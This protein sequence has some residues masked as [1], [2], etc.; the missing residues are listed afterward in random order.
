MVLDSTYDATLERAVKR[1]IARNL[2][3][4]VAGQVVEGYARTYWFTVNSFSHPATI[5]AVRL[6]YDAEGISFQCDCEGAMHDRLCAHVA[7]ALNAVEAGM[8]EPEPKPAPISVGR[9]A[10]DLLNG[11]DEPAYV[12]GRSA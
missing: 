12:H 6:Q 1:A 9:R 5:H 10:L 4:T 7:C 3:A 2:N 11:T 8:G